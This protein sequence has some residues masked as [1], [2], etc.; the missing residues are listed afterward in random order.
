IEVNVLRATSLSGLVGLLTAGAFRVPGGRWQRA[1]QA[2]PEFLRRIRV[3]PIVTF[4]ANGVPR[5]GFD[6]A[7]AAPDAESIL[8]DIYTLLDEEARQ[9]PAALVLDEFQA[10]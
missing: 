9:R 7:I 3:S 2:V 6:T 5:F 1:R 10:I 4:D 8:A